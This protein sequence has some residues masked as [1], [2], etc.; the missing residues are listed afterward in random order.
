MASGLIGTSVIG[1]NL[2]SLNTTQG[3]AF[4]T[5]VCPS[6]G[7][8]YAVV[9]VVADASFTST[10]TVVSADVIRA[11]ML[12]VQSP[13]APN[14]TDRSSLTYTVILAPGQTWTSRPEFPASS[15]ASNGRAY[16]Q[17][18]ASVLEVV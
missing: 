16:A 12:L 3:G 2:Q 18:M 7:V 17:L 6:T 15:A 14:Q 5:Y 13:Q 8:R 9:T 1:P 10:A 4:L 11:G